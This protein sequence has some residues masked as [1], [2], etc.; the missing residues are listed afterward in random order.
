MS[1]GPVPGRRGRQGDEERRGFASAE[2]FALQ[3]G[4]DKKEGRG[5]EKAS[6]SGDG[7]QAPIVCRRLAQNVS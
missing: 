4:L 1:G 6:G 5:G 3:A 7:Q 2:H